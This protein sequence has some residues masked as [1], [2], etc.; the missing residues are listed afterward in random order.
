LDP[1][2]NSLPYLFTL[3]AHIQA[4]QDHRGGESG[5]EALS[6]HPSG[7][8]WGKI[9]EFLTKFDSR[10]VRYAGAEWR[11]LLELVEAIARAIN[12]VLMPHRNLESFYSLTSLQP[13]VAVLPIRAA[14]LRLDPSS[15]T[16]TS[17]HL[18]FIRLCLDA[19][20]FRHALPI[21]DRDIQAFPSAPKPAN[22]AI[23]SRYSSSYINATS[24]L[25]D[26]LTYRHH[27]EYHLFGALI[28]MG[29]KRWERAL[30]FLTFVIVAPTIGPA[31]TIQVEAYKK[32]VLVGLLVHGGVSLIPELSKYHYV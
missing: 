30:E 8:L 28:Y 2:I 18:L 11:R 17:N 3:L 14:I 29:L 32:W 25:T 9:V 26:R 4:A 24:G 31:S 10:Q 19:K 16:L 15:S 5:Q 7:A 21:L 13:I 12:K 23:G 27:L 1:S 22:S 6:I 20:T